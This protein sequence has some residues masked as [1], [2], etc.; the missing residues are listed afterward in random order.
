[1]HIGNLSK[2][3][4]NYESVVKLSG[5]D[6]SLAARCIIDPYTTALTYLGLVQWML[7]YP[8]KARKLANEALRCATDLEHA[9]TTALVR[10]FAG[11]QLGELLRDV[12][13]TR[14]HA[15]SVIVLARQHDMRGWHPLVNALQG[16]ALGE[17]NRVQEGISQVEDA[18]AELD[19]I[20]TIV[21]RAHY[22]GILAKLHARR[23]DYAASLDVIKE[24]HKCVQKYEHYLWRAEL[25]QVEGEILRQA[26]APTEEVE[27]CLT[28][29]I[30][31]AMEQ[32]A[33]SFELRAVTSLAQ[34]WRDQGRRSDAHSLLRTTYE[35]FTEGFDTPDV[36]DAKALIDELR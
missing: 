5:P 14:E 28:T 15:D 36:M 26:G 6:R 34:L 33:K 13:A 9:N 22:L 17:V 21:H 4:S 27:R 31:W 12:P 16:W 30:N 1:M 10:V 20:A 24:A 32:E 7:G 35:W 23:G 2:A 3:R 25:Y 8:A 19:A 11:A 18:I 29:A